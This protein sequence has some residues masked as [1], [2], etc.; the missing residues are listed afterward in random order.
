LNA[1]L[2]SESTNSILHSDETSPRAHLNKV[3]IQTLV[4]STIVAQ[5]ITAKIF[6]VY[7]PAL[8]MRRVGCKVMLGARRPFADSSDVLSDL[9]GQVAYMMRIPRAIL[10]YSAAFGEGPRFTT[11]HEAKS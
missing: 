9:N 3:Y 5:A 1:L 4:S 11:D 10:V 7:S 8:F 2:V 6:K